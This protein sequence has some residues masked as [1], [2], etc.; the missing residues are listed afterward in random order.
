MRKV[1]IIIGLYNRCTVGEQVME[2]NGW[3]K[4]WWNFE[5]DTQASYTSH[6]Y[7]YFI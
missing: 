2:T 4:P 1:M 3:L 5:G 7:F 6:K